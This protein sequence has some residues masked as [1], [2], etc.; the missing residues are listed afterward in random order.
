MPT[1]PASKQSSKPHCVTPRFRLSFPALDVPV[2][3]EE[4]KGKKYSVTM[5][6]KKGTDLAK[7]KGLVRQ[8]LTTKFGADESKWPKGRR[9]PFR[10][11][12]EDKSHLDGYPGHTFVK[13]STKG[14]PGV[15]DKDNNEIEDIAE[16]VYAGCYCRA[17]I[18]AYWFEVKGNKGVAFSL[19]NVQ[20][21]AEGDPFSGRTSPQ[22]DFNDSEESSGGAEESE[23]N[24]L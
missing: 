7:L 11:G 19:N 1:Q 18:G 13:A 16:Q 9:S 24:D 12:D 14:K 17:S 20:K 2:E 3:M 23:D 4:G 21:L 15:V 5:L 22:E 8:V 6:F 10:D